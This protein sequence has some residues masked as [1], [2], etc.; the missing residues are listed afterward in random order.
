M[1]GGEFII[2][3]SSIDVFMRRFVLLLV[4]IVA[5]GIGD[6]LAQSH[7]NRTQTYTRY[8]EDTLAKCNIYFRHDGGAIDSNYRDNRS[9]L[10]L[11]RSAMASLAEDTT[12]AVSLIRIEGASSPIGHEVY[13]YRLS[14]RRARNVEKFLRTVPGLENAEISVL[15]KGEDW[16][17][18]TDDIRQNYTRRNRAALLEI[19]DSDIPNSEKK[20]RIMAMEYDQTTWKYLVRNFM[21]SSRH[22]VTLVVTKTSK[23]IE[24]VPG[25]EQLKAKA[26]AGQSIRPSENK[27]VPAALEAPK[28]PIAS[29]RTNL[30]VPGLNFG[31]ELPI[32]NNWSVAAD[33]YFPWFWPN[34]NN[35][36]CFELLGW[37]VEGRYW[38]GRDRQPHDRLKGHSIG[39]SMAGGYY[40][41]EKNYRGMQGEFVSPG[42]DYTYSMAI[43]R[44]KNMHLQFT[45]AAGYIRSWGRTYNVFSEYGELYPDEGT[46]I[47]DYFGPTKAAVSLV[48]PLYK[49]EGGR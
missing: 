31:A 23:V 48:I 15:G 2:F 9:S 16:E 35:K 1:W 40:D 26:E 39:V 43:G 25:V 34:K 22:T 20:Q 32:G 12:T 28:V 49:K 24:L 11:I 8:Q 36:N 41:F 21:R 4:F 18:F 14:L 45:V 29:L 19:L 46:V 37:S 6:T 44:K 13:N 17:T 33:Y 47:W 27:V 5:L 3:V 38:F 10:A 30:L 7:D 42:I